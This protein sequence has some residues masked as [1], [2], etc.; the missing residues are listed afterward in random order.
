MCMVRDWPWFKARVPADQTEGSKG[1]VC[2]DAETGEI[3]AAMVAYNWTMNA[4][5][6]HFAM[7]N[8][9]VFRHHFHWECFEYVFGTADRKKAYVQ[10]ASDNPKSMKFVRHL[11]F[12]EV[13]VLKDAYADGV[14]NHILE[15]K[16]ENCRYWSA[17]EIKRQANG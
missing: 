16:R 4:V 17:P 2:S 1:I 7:D 9:V 12:E 15:L 11:G 14:D 13:A 3:L 8:P 6:L 5:E 10:V